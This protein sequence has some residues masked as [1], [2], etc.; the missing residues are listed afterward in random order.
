MNIKFGLVVISLILFS[1][2]VFGET[3]SNVSL[4]GICIR[5]N[6]ESSTN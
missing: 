6:S 4:E 2:S 1:F 5:A 3:L